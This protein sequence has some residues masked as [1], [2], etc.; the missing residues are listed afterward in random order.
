MIVSFKYS[1]VYGFLDI[2]IWSGE[3]IALAHT[4]ND[5]M[6]KDSKSGIICTKNDINKIH[7]VGWVNLMDRGYNVVFVLNTIFRD[8]N[9]TSSDLS[10]REIYEEFTKDKLPEIISRYRVEKINKIIDYYQSKISPS[11]RLK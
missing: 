9:W 1:E 10:N 3:F 6:Y 8:C 11:S 4:S 7:E 5:I 2:R